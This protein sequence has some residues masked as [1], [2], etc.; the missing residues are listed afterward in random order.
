MYGLVSAASLALQCD[1]PGFVID[2]CSSKLPHPRH[3]RSCGD[4]QKLRWNA[5]RVEFAFGIGA[6]L[7][8]EE[9]CIAQLRSTCQH[10]TE[11]ACGAEL[12]E[13]NQGL[14]AGCRRVTQCQQLRRVSDIRK[15]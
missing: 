15:A 8:G 14:R 9:Q 4:E 12:G 2:L 6:V 1:K 3:L 11:I 13:P 5:D 10:I 7:A